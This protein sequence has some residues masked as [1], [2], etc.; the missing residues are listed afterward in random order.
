MKKTV[1]TFGLI[2]GAIVSLMMMITMP[3]NDEI[4]FK[5][6]EIIGF[7]T[8]FAS[9][10]L[11]YFGVRSYRENV[12]GGTV[13]FGR[14]LAVGSLIALIS[15]VMYTATW[16]VIFFG[17]KPDFA[18]KYNAHRIE[19]ARAKGASPTELEKMTV[20][21]NEFAEMYKNPLINIGFTMREILPLGLIVALISAAVVSRKRMRG[22]AMATG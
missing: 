16:Q 22:S 10:L 15:A 14:A 5:R 3:F 4:G 6:A 21:G 9:F 12:S 11:I 2:S 17:F 18:E 1:L 19:S 8:M 7:T 13:R 20:E